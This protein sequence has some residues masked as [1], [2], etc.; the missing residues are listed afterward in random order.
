MGGGMQPSFDDKNL[1]GFVLAKIRQAGAGVGFALGSAALA[2]RA[3]QLFNRDISTREIRQAV[4][5][6]RAEGQPI[7]SSGAGFFWPCCLQ[8]VMQTVELEFRSVARSELL[9]ARL[10]RDSGRRLFGGQW[11]LL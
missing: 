3:M 11:R 9:T 2:D 6:L 10:L 1:R 8:D 7:C 5:D 4:H